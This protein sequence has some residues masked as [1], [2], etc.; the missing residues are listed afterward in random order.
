M[1][2]KIATIICN[3]NYGR[4]LESSINSAINQTIEN[5]VIVVDDASDDE[6]IEIIKG[7][8][9]K[10]VSIFLDTKSGPSYARNIAI[11]EAIKAG[12]EIFAILD[13]DDE[14]YNNKLEVCVK[15]LMSNDIIGAVYADYDIHNLET[16]TIYREF[17]EPFCRIRLKN[18][19][20]VHSGAVIKKQAL[21]DFVNEN[22]F[23][24][25]TMRTCEDYELWARISKKYLITHIPE[26]LTK[27]RN[28]QMNSTNTVPQNVWQENWRKVAMAYA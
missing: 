20:M 23:Y 27:V 3:H 16:N 15:K 14:M 26:S 11:G 13:A 12:Y 2:L 22:G 19:C 7:F 28:H 5:T 18:N 4:F 9:D 8:G 25:N 24:N 21:L 6:S 17:K 1:E 10:I